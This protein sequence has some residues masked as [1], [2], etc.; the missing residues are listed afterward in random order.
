[1]HAGEALEEPGNILMSRIVVQ[2]FIAQAPEPVVI[3]NEQHTERTVIQ[4]I[5]SN[6][7]GK[8]I[9]SFVDIFRSYRC[10]TFFSPKP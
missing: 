1:M 8:I 5:S 4:L 9:K 2:H 7:T 6:V 3:D 10:L